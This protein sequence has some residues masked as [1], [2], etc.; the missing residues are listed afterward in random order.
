MNLLFPSFA[1]IDGIGG[2]EVLLIMFVILLLF[3]GEKLPVFAK[4]IGK[5]MRELK[6]ASAD[7]EREIKKAMEDTPEPPPPSTTPYHSPYPAPAI[8]TS[9]S[10][11]FPDPYT[12]DVASAPET[13]QAPVTPVTPSEPQQSPAEEKKEIPEPPKP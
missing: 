8:E 6:K 5:T 13:S 12:Q 4:T 9:Q 7:V 1:F 3:G 11:A 2:P 10:P